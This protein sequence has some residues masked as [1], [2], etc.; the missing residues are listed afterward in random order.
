MPRHL[1]RFV[2]AGSISHYVAVM[3]LVLR[4]SPTSAAL[5]ACECGCRR[6]R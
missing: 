2:L 4:P 3:S 1:A 5:A 6:M